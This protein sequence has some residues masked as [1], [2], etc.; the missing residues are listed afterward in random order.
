MTPDGTT[1]DVAGPLGREAEAL[2]RGLGRD[3][4]VRRIED[5][6]IALQRA[7]QRQ[8]VVV[9]VV[10]ESGRGKS[11]LVNALVGVP[12][13]SPASPG[14]DTGIPLIVSFGP[15]RRAWAVVPE[16]GRERRIPLRA[17]Q[18]HGVV[19]IGSDGIVDVAEE[20]L[21]AAWVEVELTVPWLRGL[22]IVDTPGIGGLVPSHGRLAAAALADA[23]VVVCVADAAAPMAR[24]ECE[25]LAVAQSRVEAVIVALAKK[26][27]FPSWRAV[28]EADRQALA[29]MAPAGE[30]PPLLPV[31]SILLERALDPGTPASLRV[32]LETSSGI[33]ALRQAIDGWAADG[34]HV[35]R[36]TSFCAVLT[37]IAQELRGHAALRLTALK[38]PPE[39]LAALQAEVKRQQ[40][41]LGEATRAAVRKA[42][43][44]TLS[45][46]R[47]VRHDFDEQ[48]R[49]I[50]AR[51]R[52]AALEGP[53]EE[54]PEL[55]D[56]MRADLATAAATALA[57]FP[58]ALTEM[59]RELEELLPG[60]EPVTGDAAH[61]LTSPG[62]DTDLGTPLTSM[63]TSSAGN[64]MALVGGATLGSSIVRLTLGALPLTG[65]LTLVP[66]I[67][68]ALTAA[69]GVG[70]AWK[71]ISAQSHQSQRQAVAGWVDR[72]VGEIL[73][74][75]ARTSDRRQVEL[76][77]LVEST[78]E[79]AFSARVA[80][81]DV[82][83]RQLATVAEGGPA[84][85]SGA[86][87][88]GDGSFSPGAIGWSSRA[89]RFRA[90]ARASASFVGHNDGPMAGGH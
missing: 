5:L 76:S 46:T 63:G 59:C 84:P 62:L 71:R 82:L 24:P 51:Y 21:S 72:A 26:D 7:N 18:V 70:L 27:A 60:P 67:G 8:D 42:G 88:G 49:A 15:E 3:D 17:D 68:A 69:V 74:D 20:A 38:A 11:S 81:L 4:L 6:V 90:N 39:E 10:G 87:R 37:Q 65:A 14:V 25:F 80:A 35:L 36:L 64:A 85:A 47:L 9:A 43:S 50:R 83:R 89:R 58:D 29:A 44:R 55:P 53:G 12:D 2:A 52:T 61:A 32:A 79:V 73:A 19:R 13:L 22:R 1:A 56:R 33:S 16:D 77:E 41:A 40:D 34:P 30:P 23:D 86:H 54:L 28:M 57:A 45:R 78:I 48:A 31:S 66:W 75:F